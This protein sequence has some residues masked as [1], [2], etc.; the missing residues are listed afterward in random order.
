M[1]TKI[2]FKELLTIISE[3]PKGKVP[4]YKHLTETVEP[5]IINSDRS[6]LCYPYSCATYSLVS[7]KNIF[8][9]FDYNTYTYESEIGRADV[10][11]FFMLTSEY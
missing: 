10:V 6:V 5:L 4:T 9:V 8:S 3:K 1:S 2:K 11:V 7:G